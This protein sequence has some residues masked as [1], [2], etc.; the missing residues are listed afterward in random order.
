[1]DQLFIDYRDDDLTDL[2]PTDTTGVFLDIHS[3]GEVILSSWG[4][5][6]TPPPN[7]DGI[8]SLARKMAFHNGYRP[9]L[10]SLGTVDGAT[11]DYAYGRFGVPGYTLEL[12]TAFFEDCGFFEQSIVPQNLPALIYAAKASRQPYRIALGPDVTNLSPFMTPFTA[13]DLVQLHAI[14]DDQRYLTGGGTEPSQNVSEAQYSVATPPWDNSA[15]VVAMAPADGAFDAPQE[16]IEGSV[17]TQGFA[18][19]Q[20]LIYVRAKDAD[21]HWGAVSAVFLDVI[22]PLTAPLINGT[23]TDRSTGAPLAGVTVY[24]NDY[25]VITDPLGE[26]QLQLPPGTYD[27]MVD[28]PGYLP[29]QISA[30]EVANGD[31]SQQD[32]SLIPLVSVYAFDGESGIQDWQPGGQWVLSTE[33]AHSPTH[34]WTDSES[35]DYDNSTDQSLTSAAIDFSQ[36]SNASLSFRHQYDFESNFDYGRVEISIDNQS[37]TQLQAFSGASPAG[38]WSEAIFDL[39]DYSS[40]ATVYIR[41]RVTSDS[42]VTRD[43]WHIDDVNISA[44]LT[45]LPDLIFADSFDSP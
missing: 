2:A 19:G 32:F 43:G 22:D 36:V 4:F 16:S 21:G 18:A 13:G 29:V 9:Q 28:I 37:W 34:A 8:L 1:M 33:A 20:H 12:G 6:N 41:F 40:A 3:F 45:I 31:S 27:L 38:V 25:Q 42:S 24:L 11:K 14:A 5:T 30:V 15:S 23:V 35:G 26:Y 7:G 17:D 10:G 39:Q 44:P